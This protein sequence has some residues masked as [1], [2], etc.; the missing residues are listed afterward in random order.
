MTG[1]Q[2]VIE[3]MSGRPADRTPVMPIIHNA[4]A[5]YAGQSLGSYFTDART[6]ADVIV[7]G[8]ERFGFDGVQLTLGVT[9]EAQA[10]GARV[11]QPAEGAPLLREHILADM[12]RLDS[13]RGIDPNAAGRLPL[14]HEAVAD[15]CRRIGGQTFV[16]TTLRGPLNIA[17]QLRGVEDVLVDM[18]QQPDEVAR[19]LDFATDVAVRV[20]RPSLDAGADGL[21]F[22]EATCSPNFI[23]PKMYREL[24]LPRHKRLV[25]E[26][27]AQGW[28]FVAL[29]ICGN[30]VPILEDMIS[31]GLDFVD[32]DYQVPAD[33]AIALSAGRVALRGNLD[34]IAVFYNGSPDEVRKTTAD[35]CRAVA[36]SRWIAST[37]CDIP[38]GTPA[39]N[40][41]AF[42]DTVRA[43]ASWSHKRLF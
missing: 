24:V 27:K 32:I 30:V 16:L 31:T 20:S 42:V 1:K 38:P 12:S 22:G 2:R 36:G 18:L 33:R 10:L 21:I 29:H 41:A 28:R 34:P 7:G 37:G 26:V 39:D 23:S 13:L 3:V 11:D 43:T 40:V 14:Y 35:L 9:G 19:L 6:M 25:A 8:C 17:S 4:L 5:K 15:V